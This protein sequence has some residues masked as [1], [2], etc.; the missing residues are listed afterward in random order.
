MKALP[1]TASQFQKRLLAW[2]DLHGRKH[3]PWQH[4]KTPYRVWISEIMLQQTQVATVIPYYERF[5]KQFPTLASLAKAHEDEVMRHFAGLGYYSRAR[6][7]HR[8]ARIIVEH[9][10][11][12]F[13][14]EIEDMKALPGIGQSTAGAIA[15]IAFN[16]STTI[17]DGN[18]K[19][20]L[21]RLHYVT[22]A[23]TD[24]KIE[25]ELW[26]IAK[27]YTPNKRTAD[28]TQAMMDLGA[29]LCTPK[30][31]SCDHC[32]FVTNC[33]SYKHQAVNEIPVKKI[34]AQLPVKQSTFLIIKQ[35]QLV[36][37]YKRPAKG[38]WGGLFS[39][40]EIEGLQDQRNIQKFCKNNLQ[41]LPKTLQTLSPFRH[42]FTHFHLDIYPVL[43]EITE[44]SQQKI[45]AS[46]PYLWYNLR[47]NLM[48]GCPKPVQI[49]LKRLPHANHS[50]L[51]IK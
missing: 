19:R 15:A 37:L 51:Q 5:M 49:L 25:Q 12:E 2:F 31:P 8:A 29:T 16:Q 17:L 35:N 24:K 47:E 32:P 30:K 42:T 9:H 4:N 50:L 44:K 43:I 18:V 7:L 38:I 1:L 20:V 36:F 40:P 45:T 22:E 10:Q 41:I 46:L 33:L 39:L 34:V 26:A 48:V 28:Y 11:G 23:I 13:P 21:S 3:L 14:H 27:Y 6:N